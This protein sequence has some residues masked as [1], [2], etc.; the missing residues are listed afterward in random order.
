MLLST[1]WKLGLDNKHDHLLLPKLHFFASGAV[2]N[3]K[4]LK[5]PGHSNDATQQ[6]GNTLFAFHSTQIFPAFECSLRLRKNLMAAFFFDTGRLE[7]KED[8]CLDANF[9]VF[10]CLAVS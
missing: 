5:I 7:K 4:L 2:F 8:N 3:Q 9:R 1:R 10:S 6:C